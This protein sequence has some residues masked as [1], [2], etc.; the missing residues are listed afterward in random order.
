M[1]MNDNFN[2]KDFLLE[3]E[4]PK[5]PFSMELCNVLEF[6]KNSLSKELPTILISTDYFLLSVLSHRQNFL[7]F[8]FER[9]LTTN[10]IESIYN[11]LYQVVSSKALSALKNNRKPHID[12]IL[13]KYISQLFIKHNLRFFLN[14]TD[15]FNKI[16]ITRP[17]LLFN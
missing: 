1:N 16:H 10:S 17:L 5:L 14:L 6:M 15:F 11:V 12:V 7:C 3:A 2:V 8:L 13:K 9:C 4:D